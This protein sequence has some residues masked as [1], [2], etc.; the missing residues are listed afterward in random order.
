MA[1]ITEIASLDTG[2]LQPK[3]LSDREWQIIFEIE[4][5]LAEPLPPEL[6]RDRVRMPASLVREQYSARKAPML[7]P[8]GTRRSHAER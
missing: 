5:R 4:R 8:H 3:Q 1:E 6:N 2:P 7:C